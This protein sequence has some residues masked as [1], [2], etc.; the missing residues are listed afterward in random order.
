M[1]NLAEKIEEKEPQ[2][3]K[4]YYLIEGKNRPSVSMCTS[5]I[6]SSEGLI[7][8]GADCGAKGVIWELG[9]IRSVEALKEKLDSPAAIQ[10]AIEQGRRGLVSER[11]RVT[12]FGHV[13]HGG[14]EYIAK[15][16]DV[17]PSEWPENARIAFNT[18]K[19]FW[20]DMN[21]NVKA[22][23]KVV[24]STAHGYGG[25]L[26][27]M[28][29]LEEEDCVKLKPYLMKISDAPTPG[30]CVT[31]LKTGS[32]YKQKHAIQL[33][34]YSQAY[35]ETMQREVSGGLIINIPREKPEEIDCCF[36]NEETL[37]DA[38]KRG[39]LTGKA[40]WEFLEAP[41]WYKRENNL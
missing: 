9:K 28:V 35:L 1:S 5:S 34:A 15:G 12:D 20:D 29:K 25:R 16:I 37:S 10:W 38:F 26:D 33:S 32:F 17:D 27:L 23:E 4:G 14:L 41:Q 18:L 13:Q 31:D 8:W 6:G 3:R 24:F 21:F 39:F 40:A 36:F 7:Y 2:R 11:D 19:S 30:Y 22:V